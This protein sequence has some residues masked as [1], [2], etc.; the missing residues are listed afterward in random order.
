[1]TRQAGGE[2]K[3]PRGAEREGKRPRDATREGHTPR[4]PGQR[5]QPERLGALIEEAIRGAG[6]ETR[7]REAGIFAV[8]DEAVGKRIA[9]VA[10][11]LSAKRGVATVEVTAPAWAQELSG[12]APKL[13]GAVNERLGAPAIRELRFV[14]Q[15][16]YP[17]KSDR[18]PRKDHDP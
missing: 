18:L 17:R 5:R 8:W 1:M 6:I 16:L 9:K 3:R 13:V 11:P 12:L 4:H 2:G 15:G 14:L 7:V 10:R